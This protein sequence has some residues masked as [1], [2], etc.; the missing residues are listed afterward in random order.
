M[1]SRTVPPRSAAI[2]S[3]AVRNGALVTTDQS[4]ALKAALVVIE[5]TFGC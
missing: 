5:N 2:T 1:D 3:M 4:S